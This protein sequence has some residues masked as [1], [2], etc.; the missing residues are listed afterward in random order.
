MKLEVFIQLD[1]N[2]Q[3]NQLH[4]FCGVGVAI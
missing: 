4:T 2:P 3:R 1:G